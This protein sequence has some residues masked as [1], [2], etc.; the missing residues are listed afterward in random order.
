MRIWNCHSQVTHKRRQYSNAMGTKKVKIT[1]AA[2]DCPFQ[3]TYTKIKVDSYIDE[4]L[5]TIEREIAHTC[6]DGSGE[7]ILS[8][9]WL[10]AILEPHEKYIRFTNPAKL[11]KLIANLFDVVISWDLANAVYDQL[12]FSSP[13]TGY[14]RIKPLLDAFCELNKGSH[15]RMIRGKQNKKFEYAFLCPGAAINALKHS[16]KVVF[17]DAAFLKGDF[18]FQIF[19]AAGADGNN[20]IVPL[21][22]GLAPVENLKNWTLFM[23]DL[24]QSLGP[25]ADV[26]FMSDC[27]KGLI[28][29]IKEVFGEDAKHSRCFCHLARILATSIAKHGLVRCEPKDGVALPPCPKATQE[30]QCCCPDATLWA[31]AK[32]K[33]DEPSDS[34]TEPQAPPIELSD[35]EDSVDVLAKPEPKKGTQA[36]AE[37]GAQARAEEGG[38]ERNGGKR[39]G[40]EGE[41]G[42]GS[43]SA[44]KRNARRDETELRV[45]N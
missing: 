10:Q 42:E 44:N 41:E 27:A 16:T 19:A 12:T 40:E 25:C 23:N 45:R 37:N 33:G 32:S 39:K 6:P 9:E 26:V 2:K 3:L 31:L 1:C 38:Q 8:R 43:K 35:H 14:D 24:K 13:D 30:A 7:P 20:R 28:G 18:G 34:E 29:S 4:D 17:A 15:T 11:K 5:F 21:A 36:R 22:F